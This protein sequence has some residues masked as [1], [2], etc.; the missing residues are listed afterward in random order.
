[1]S[2][3]KPKPK[4]NLTKPVVADS[5]PSDKAADISQPPAAPVVRS[6]LADWTADDE[7]VNGFY[8][9][10]KRQR[11][12]RKKRKKNVVE[13][14]AAVDWDEIYDPSRPSNYWEYIGSEEQMRER[15][16]W[17]DKLYAH[18]RER[19]RR[20]SSSD[21]SDNGASR[22]K[23][24]SNGKSTC[25][26]VLGSSNRNDLQPVSRLRRTTPLHHRQSHRMHLIFR[27]VLRRLQRC[28]MIPLAKMHMPAV[29]V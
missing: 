27:P 1:M 25:H 20:R 8:A 7:D 5:N 3:Q 12:G 26:K 2:T 23:A 13:K 29:Y 10:E 17:K 24:A 15:R 16:E 18:R 11:G 9:G 21:L 19:A 28:Q 4:Q 22:D 14:P 6:T